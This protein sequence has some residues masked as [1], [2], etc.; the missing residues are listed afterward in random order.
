MMHEYNIYNSFSGLGKLHYDC[1]YR[2]ESVPLLALKTTISGV[3]SRLL[4]LSHL[5]KEADHIYTTTTLMLY[6]K[7]K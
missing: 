5:M 3:Q 7:T 1:T 4:C 2:G 6:E